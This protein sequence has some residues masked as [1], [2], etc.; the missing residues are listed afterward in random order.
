MGSWIH[1]VE[2]WGPENMES[3]HGVLESWSRVMESSHGYRV[4]HSYSFSLET[5]ENV[6]VLHFARIEK[7]VSET[8]AP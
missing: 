3:S 4:R 6:S 7:N 2:T 8:G 5:G 1:G